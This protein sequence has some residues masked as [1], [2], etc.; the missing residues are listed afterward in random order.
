MQIPNRDEAFEEDAVATGAAAPP[1]E[2]E[3]SFAQRANDFSNIAG[4][5]EDDG[6]AKN[7]TLMLYFCSSYFCFKLV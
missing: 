3:E 6:Y 7:N 1:E 5:E 4:E 2:T